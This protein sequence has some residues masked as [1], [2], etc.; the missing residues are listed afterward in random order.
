M[1]TTPG[2]GGCGAL[3]LD[4]DGTPFV[5]V[6]S[7]PSS[8]PSAPVLWERTPGGWVAVP[9]TV[10]SGSIAVDAW[11]RLHMV[12][13]EPVPNGSVYDHY[14]HYARMEQRTFDAAVTDWERFRGFERM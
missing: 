9:G 14:L 12:A 6:V 13:E 1:T 3:A 11:G 7:K 8:G 10:A 5:Y 4:M 2:G